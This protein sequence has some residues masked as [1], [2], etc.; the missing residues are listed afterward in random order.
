[1][2]QRRFP[3][4]WSIVESPESFVVKDATGQKT[5][6]DWRPRGGNPPGSPPGG[7]RFGGRSSQTATLFRINKESLPDG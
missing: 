6:V 2:A 4:P 1:M 3:P 7:F 5:L